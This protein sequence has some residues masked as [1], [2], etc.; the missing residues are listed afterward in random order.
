MN[1]TESHDIYLD[2]AATTPTHPDVL[3]AMLPFFTTRAGNPSSVHHRGRAAHQGL[4]SARRAVAGILGCRTREVVFT[5]GGSEADNLAIKG[6]AYQHRA[7]GHPSSHV[8]SIPIE[9]H[10]VGHTLDHLA[11]QGFAVTQVPVDRYG[12]VAVAEIERAI[13]PDTCL[14]TVMY[15]NNEV[16]TIQPI[17]AL[18]ALAHRHGILFHTDAVQAGGSLPIRVDELQVD[19]LSLSAHKFY[20]PKGV[21]VL[22][23]RS[24]TQ[25]TPLLHGGGQEHSVRAGTENVPGIVGLAAAL[26]RAYAQAPAEGPRI[27]ALRDRLIAGIL[28]RIPDA[29]LQG[30][31]T[32]RLPNNAAFCFAGVSGEDLLLRLDLA[33]ICASSGSA[34]TSGSTKPSHVLTACGTPLDLARG[35]LRLTLGTDNTA[36]DVDYTL[37]TLEQIVSEL[38]T[39]LP[40]APAR[41]AVG[42]TATGSTH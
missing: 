15:A 39:R 34:C 27:T 13:R 10:A 5:G 22:Y 8:I 30:H 19:L 20:G 32:E 36:D 41:T 24:G 2:H 17:A 29:H 6:V 11:S 4:E 40:H 1:P 35:S 42:A 14:I 26:T 12:Q 21:G 23:V 33:G 28:A 37:D 16:G 38:R 3:Q 9:H 18:G 7:A 31:P 25:L